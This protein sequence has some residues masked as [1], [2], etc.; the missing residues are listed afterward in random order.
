MTVVQLWSIKRGFR[1]FTTQNYPFANHRGTDLNFNSRQGEIYQTHF[2]LTKQS[3]KRCVKTS[4]RFF[5]D[6]SVVFS[7][8]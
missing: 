6:I 3:K 7:R 8:P 5:Q 2:E 4:Q 1:V